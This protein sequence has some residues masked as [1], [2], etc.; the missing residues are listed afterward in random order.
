MHVEEAGNGKQGMRSHHQ[1]TEE[2]SAQEHGDAVK[3]LIPHDRRK[4][5]GGVPKV[6]T[7]EDKLK[8]GGN[9]IRN[10]ATAKPLP[11]SDMANWATGDVLATLCIRNEGKMEA[12]EQMLHGICAFLLTVQRI[13]GSTAWPALSLSLCLGPKVYMQSSW[14]V[15]IYYN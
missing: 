13:R 3:E 11:P 10:R 4:P 1:G 8:E 12:E 9:R 14:Q 7:T 6:I 2:W 15:V 5:S